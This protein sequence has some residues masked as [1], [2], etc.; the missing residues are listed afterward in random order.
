M[1]REGYIPKG[2]N[3]WAEA[4]LLREYWYAF[5]QR[6]WLI[7]AVAST[8]L[9]G[10]AIGSFLQTPQYKATALLQISRG[11][12]NLVQDVMIEDAGTGYG[13]FYYT[14]EGILKSRSLAQRVLDELGLRQHPLFGGHA[15][16]PEDNPEQLRANQAEM[17]LERLEI[18]PVTDTQLVQISFT[19]PDPELSARLANALANQY[20]AY[21]AEA[22]AEIARSTTTF[23]LEQIERIQEE[24]QEKETLLQEYSKSKDILVVDNQQ[25]TIV[26]R[27]EGLSRELT[28]VQ[29]ERAAAEAHYRS[30]QG[31]ELHSFPEVLGDAGVENL[32]REY[33][34]LQKKY[35]ELSN[36][37]KANYPEMKRTESAM[38]DVQRR[39]DQEIL[40]VANR[41]LADAR[42]RYEAARNR[43]AILRRALESQEQETRDLNLFDADYQRIKVG[44]DSQRAMLQ[45]LLRRQSETGLSAELGERQPVTVRLVDEAIVPTTPYRPNHVLNLSLGGLFGLLLAVGLA[46]FLNY[47]DRSLHNV[48]DVRRYVPLPFLGLI[49]RDNAEKKVFPAWPIEVSPLAAPTSSSLTLPPNV[50]SARSLSAGTQGNE[51]LYG[52]LSDALTNDPS[53]VEHLSAITR[54]LVKAR[55]L[56]NIEETAREVSPPNSSLAGSDAL[57]IPKASI[58]GS[59]TALLLRERFKFLRNSVLLSNAEAPTRT[60]LITSASAGEGKTFIACH[61]AAS[62]SELGKKVLLVDADLRKPSLHRVLGKDNQIGL[63][64]V[65]AG[66]EYNDGLIHSTPLRNLRV[67]LAGPSSPAPAELL[68]SF[69]TERFLQGLTEQFDFVVLDSAP[70]LPVVDSHV[71]VR[72]CDAALLVARSGYTSRYAV[73]DSKELVER[74]KGHLTGVV[75]NDVDLNDYAQSYYYGHYSSRYG[76]EPPIEK[77]DDAAE[78]ERTRSESL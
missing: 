67:I 2:E 74:E 40:E 52:E 78:E 24:I 69:V 62:L 25:S 8:V 58:D 44:L 15:D 54:A 57:P 48:E 38:E 19:S 33:A 37:F 3:N 22:V 59:R 63:S 23:I 73:K 13:E 29:A 42:V 20:I 51:V 65:L 35:A 9:A 5:L 36:R 50:G 64:N 70:L 75:L 55:S 1:H 21:S 45:Q 26:Q 34:D 30:M 32:K 10:S 12:I 14:Q 18:S 41:V 27:L 71:L 4:D 17:L 60:I 72:L 49:P 7:V 68:G 53:R 28:V 61:L 11:K 47:W 76:A 56:A 31:E 39:L 66:G 43:E 77:L 46:F 16:T 6:R